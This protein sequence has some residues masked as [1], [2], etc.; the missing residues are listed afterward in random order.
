MTGPLQLGVIHTCRQEPVQQ[1][2]TEQ[3]A[4]STSFSSFLKLFKTFFV[5]LS[6]SYRNLINIRVTVLETIRRDWKISESIHKNV[7]LK[8]QHH[9]N[10]LLEV[11]FEKFSHPRNNRMAS[12]LQ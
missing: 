4:F 6:I 7:S 10:S 8:G 9:N 3:K 2:L 5:S 1:A 12:Y 11:N